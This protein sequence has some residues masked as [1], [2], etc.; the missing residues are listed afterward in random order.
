MNFHVL[1][2]IETV[3]SKFALR[4]ADFACASYQCIHVHMQTTA[5]CFVVD[6]HAIVKP[7]S[8]NRLCVV[9]VPLITG[10]VIRWSASVHCCACFD[11]KLSS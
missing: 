5:E 1:L 11:R 9:V 8:I 4:A 7:P 2:L 3:K 10:P 6:A